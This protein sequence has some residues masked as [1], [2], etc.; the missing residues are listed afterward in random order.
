[1]VKDPI[2]KIGEG[3]HFSFLGIAHF[4]YPVGRSF[5]C[6]RDNHLVQFQKVGFLIAVKHTNAIL[7]C[8]ALA[9]IQFSLAQ[10]IHAAELLVYVIM[11]FHYLVKIILY[12]S[13]LVFPKS[14]ASSDVLKTKGAPTSADEYEIQNS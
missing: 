5:V 4:E 8:L 1:M 6:A 14:V 2:W 11:P 3:I 10:V 13:S 7:A 9:G 12:K